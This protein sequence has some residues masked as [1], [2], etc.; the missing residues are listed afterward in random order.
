ML[1]IVDSSPFPTFAGPDILTVI[2][3]AGQRSRW[4]EYAAAATLGSVLGAWLNF[5]LAR[6][7]GQAYID[8]KFKG[9]RVRGV[10]RIFRRWS[11]GILVA[12]TAIPLPLPTG[13][14]FAAA[15]VSNYPVGKFIGIVTFGRAVRYSAEAIIAAYYGRRVARFFLHPGQYWGWFVAIFVAVCAIITGVIVMNRR[16]AADSEKQPARV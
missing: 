5:R 6:K 4:Y 2:L 12:S 10:L 13:V 9:P 15:G 1:A 11:A 16:L 7:A 3:A 14:L 8:R